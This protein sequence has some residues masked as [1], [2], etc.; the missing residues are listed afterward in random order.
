MT[1]LSQFISFNDVLLVK[2]H[3]VKV[4]SSPRYQKAKFTL[5]ESEAQLSR[6][7]QDIVQ[8]KELGVCLEPLKNVRF[9]NFSNGKKNY[10]I[11]TSKL[12][13]HGMKAYMTKIFSSESRHKICVASYFINLYLKE[14]YQTEMNNFIDIE[15]FGVTSGFHQQTQIKSYRGYVA[16]V[17]ACLRI[18]LKYF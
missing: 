12:D 18:G 15:V 13:C 8:W 1:F 7:F 17:S 10:L 14:V 3:T 16:M 4:Q 5:V 11:D 6:A 2:P 9:V